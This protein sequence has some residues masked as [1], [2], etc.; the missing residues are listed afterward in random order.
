MS[1]ERNRDWA[2]PGAPSTS[3]L[4]P[5]SP[6][7]LPQ[8]GADSVPGVEETALTGSYDAIRQ[9]NFRGA[10]AGFPGGPGKPR[11]VFGSSIS[12]GL[13]SSTLTS[14]KVSTFTF[15]ANRA[16]RYMSHTQASVIDTSKNTSPASVRA[17]T[18]TWLHR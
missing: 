1:R 7:G 12:A 6:S 4:A 13:S 9:K 10:G 5:P 8:F 18:S 11:Q 2:A 16:G 3:H 14:L 15:F 17:F